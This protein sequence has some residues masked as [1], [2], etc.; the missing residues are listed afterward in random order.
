MGKKKKIKT[1]R[2]DLG[3]KKLIEF[4]TGMLNKHGEL[5]GRNKK[6]TKILKD[7]C[8]HHRINKKGK[9]KSRVE[10][11]GGV[12]HCTMCNNDFTA[13]PY[14]KDERDRICGDFYELV[15]N[16]KFMAAATHADENVQR[17]LAETA[18]NVRNVSKISKTLT[19]VVE[20]E[21]RMS[22]KEKKNSNSSS[23][24]GEWNLRR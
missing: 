24:L 8:M 22:K 20:K 13:K 3:G 12:A 15:N 1:T 10:V 19:K 2:I 6:E 23:S 9:L 16:A 4:Q 5:K 17:V 18:V 11:A 21:D 7:T 14:S